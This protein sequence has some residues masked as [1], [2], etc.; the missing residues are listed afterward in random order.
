MENKKTNKQERIKIK[1]LFI[2]LTLEL[3]TIFMIGQ[4]G[5]SQV[6]ISKFIT[7]SLIFIL[8][9]LV[10]LTRK[11][12]RVFSILFFTLVYGSLIIYHALLGSESLESGIEYIWLSLIPI[13][14]ITAFFL[15]N[16]IEDILNFALK[17]E[18]EQTLITID[19]VTGYELEGALIKDLKIEMVKSKRHKCNLC[20]MIVELQYKNELKK[21]YSN[22]E[23]NEIYLAITNSINKLARLE[24][25]KY[26]YKEDQFVLVLPFTN[27]E[28]IEIVK[29]RFK[30]NLKNIKL[31]SIG[32]GE[33]ILTFKYKIAI[34]EYDGVS[35]DPI[36]FLNVVQKELEYDV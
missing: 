7:Q 17:K 29:K 2:I 9:A 16:E 19:K 11:D 4:L 18:I 27:L 8:I 34:K 13:V 30:E 24:D 10:I 14:G 35:D 26:R 25:M 3:Y 12:L 21:L 28:G 5:A 23:M 22:S 36:E 33:D 6:S 15:I 20:V 1:T 32:K 31:S